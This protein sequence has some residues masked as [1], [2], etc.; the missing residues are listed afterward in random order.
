MKVKVVTPGSTGAGGMRVY[1]IACTSMYCGTGGAKC[2]TCPN[3]PALEE[4]KAWVQRT[5]ARVTDPIWC[6]LVYTV[7]GALVR[8]S[9]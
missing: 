2:R 4:F 5:G 7:P 9:G 1:P 6:P 8:L 3:G